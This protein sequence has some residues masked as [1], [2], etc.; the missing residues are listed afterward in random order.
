MGYNLLDWAS[1]D[2]NYQ[3]QEMN[4]NDEFSIKHE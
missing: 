2:S 1:G 4:K 3:F